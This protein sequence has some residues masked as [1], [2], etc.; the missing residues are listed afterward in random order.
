VLLMM[1]VM[2]RLARPDPLVQGGF[3]SLPLSLVPT[4]IIPVVIVSHLLIFLWWFR[5]KPSGGI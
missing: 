4:F 1:A 3:T 2:T 5:Q